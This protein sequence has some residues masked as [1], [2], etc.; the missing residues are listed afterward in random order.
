MLLK[1]GLLVGLNLAASFVVIDGQPR[2][3][4][5][6]EFLDRELDRLA[7]PVHRMLDLALLLWRQG[8]AERILVVERRHRASEWVEGV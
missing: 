2:R 4:A 8:N 6:L 3:D 7:V 5:L 1:Y